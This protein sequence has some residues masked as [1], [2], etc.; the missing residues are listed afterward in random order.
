MKTVLPRT[1][2]LMLMSAL[3]ANAAEPLI[4]SIE[5]QTLFKNRDGKNIT[6]FHPRA[7]LVPDGESGSKVLMTMQEIGGSDYFGPVHWLESKDQ[8]ITWSKPT[9]IKALDRIPVKSHPGL[10]AGVCDVVPE[11]HPHSDTTLAMGH[12]V[13]YRGPRFSRK[14]QLQRYPVYAVRDSKGEWSERKILKWDDPRGGY[15]YSNNCGQRVVMDNGDILLAFTFGPRAENRSVASVLCSFDGKDLEIKEVGPA[16]ELKH[17]RGL[18][19]PSLTKFKNHY[20]LTI[21]A[22]DDRGYMSVSSDGLNWEEKKPWAWDD[23]SPLT[24]STTQQHW[25][26]H[27]DGLFL[28]YTRK[29]KQNTGVMRWRSPLWIAQVDI[30]NR[31]LIRSTEQV[32]LPLVGDGVNAPN[33]VALMG[34]FHIT[35]VSPEESWVTVGEWKPKKN[36]RGDTLLA[37]IVWSSP[38]RLAGFKRD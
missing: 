4:Q 25:L 16:L 22:E 31:C 13:F 30:E 5:K 32:V 38:N 33:D 14:D 12:V 20:Y 10:K 2:A 18:L 26:T 36:A 29:D 3:C 19:E 35:N 21:R 6:W 15:I 1:L 9:P 11:Y 8:G 24:M 23:G 7:G 28:V 37:R 17:K 27:S 34:N